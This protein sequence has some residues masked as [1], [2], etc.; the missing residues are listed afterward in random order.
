VKLILRSGM[1][2]E[3][4]ETAG[5]SPDEIF[6]TPAALPPGQPAVAAIA[7]PR[8]KG[9]RGK[10]GKEPTTTVPEKKPE[11]EEVYID[12]GGREVI[13]KLPPEAR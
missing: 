12:R 11:G 4:V 5:I 7:K 10:G 9:P 8:G 13:K 1:D 2:K 3:I 6:G